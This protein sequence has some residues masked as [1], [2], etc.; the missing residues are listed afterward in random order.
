MHPF[1]KEVN[2]KGI[3]FFLCLSFDHIK[4]LDRL[5]LLHLLVFAKEKRERERENWQEEMQEGEGLY[6]QT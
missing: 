1:L 4:H 6:K 5:I 3:D 2:T